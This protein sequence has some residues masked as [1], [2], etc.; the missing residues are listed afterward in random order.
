[1]AIG[2]PAPVALLLP[3]K[4]TKR[5]LI[6]LVAKQFP[7]ADYLSGQI[8]ALAEH[9]PA[10]IDIRLRDGDAVVVHATHW[11]PTIRRTDYHV[12][13]NHASARH[14]G[15]WSHTLT[16][17]SDCWVLLWKP[18]QNGPTA[19]YAE[20]PQT[21]DPAARTLIPALS[22]IP[23]G[24]WPSPYGESST[25]E[26]LHFVSPGPPRCANV[27]VPPR[28][29]CV[30]VPADM[31]WCLR[32]GDVLPAEHIRNIDHAAE[33]SSL[34]VGIPSSRTRP[35]AKLGL[36]STIMLGAQARHGGAPWA[37]VGGIVWSLLWLVNY[38]PA[39]GAPDPTDNDAWEL[40]MTG[41]ADLTAR[42]HEHWWR[43]PLAA[44]L[45][46]PSPLS[47]QHAWDSF[48]QWYGGV[49]SSIFIATDGSGDHGGSWAVVAWGYFKRRWYRMGWA[50][51]PLDETPWLPPE[52]RQC[53][54]RLASFCGELAALESAGLWLCS[55][56]DFW[57]LHTSAKPDKVT[58]AVDNAAA[59]Q[60]A[61]GHGKAANQ[62][63]RLTR[64]VW[65]SAQARINTHFRHVHS[66]TGLLANS[67]ADALATSAA[68]R[69]PCCR[70]SPTAVSIAPQEFESSFEHLWLIPSCCVREG[71][72]VLLVPRCVATPLVTASSA[73]EEPR[74]GQTGQAAPT[75]LQVHVMSANIQTI[76]DAPVS[77]FNPSGL[78]ARRQYLYL[79]AQQCAADIVC[80]QETRSATGRW[81][82]PG[83]LTWRS[84]AVKGQYG[85]EI[86]I[87]EGVTVPPLSQSDWKIQSAGPRILAITCTAQHFPV[88]V[89][90]AH[91][92][93]ADRPDSEARQ[94]W[95]DLHAVVNRVPSSRALVIGI[96]ANGDLHASDPDGLL[97]GDLLAKGE[98]GRNDDLLLEF[99][100]T[101]GLEAPATFGDQ[102]YGPSWTWQ[103]TSGRQ[104]RIDHLLFRP[105]PWQHHLAAQAFDFDIVN[106]AR[107]HVAI[108]LRATLS[109]PRRTPR[110]IRPRSA[111]REEVKCFGADL[112]EQLHHSPRQ[113]EHPEVML[114]QLAQAFRQATRDLPPKPAPQVR[115]PYLHSH[116]VSL[117]LYLRDWRSQVRIL[118]KDWRM[119]ILRAVW[120]AWTGSQRSYRY[121]LS[122]HRLVL[123]AYTLQEYRLQARVHRLARKDKIRHFDA[124]TKAAVEE[125]HNTGQPVRAIVHLISGLPSERQKRERSTPPE[126]TTL[127][128]NSKSSFE[129][130]KEG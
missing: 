86:W 30:Q 3:S 64:Q 52:G 95:Q 115:Q 111:T 123:G 45:P 108:R 28:M 14:Q 92:P 58:I 50:A 36:V 107:D 89:I 55:V 42:L 17:H 116:T 38:L 124:L 76:K 5:L 23:D 27:I 57:C 19:L 66:H 88:S 81:K 100:L 60:V 32:D 11:S 69:H 101:H 59:L 112:W 103:H 15:C 130:K 29:T 129:H 47:L 4:V 10:D 18:G 16:F 63:A 22:H 94:F 90:S 56:I 97:I 31:P 122:Q 93:H 12:F 20:G 120:S 34:P 83:L 54:G 61:A 68:K 121:E 62:V 7:H 33:S 48:P 105:G 118:I 9:V 43:H 85:C 44:S 114:D 70:I 127:A 110:S 106:G 74:E 119:K 84:G 125:W 82:G 126:A 1:M 65:Q 13:P 51:A 40:D 77:I 98:P 49:P 25:N 6:E 24:W 80:L 67:L 87:R 72:P 53:H 78:A 102:Q 26:P 2:A 79:Q 99:C 73:P 35:T 128:T 91:A 46:L 41:P 71:R 109:C 21:W 8:P 75:P 117:L 113:W 37:A 104:K 39:Y 96:D